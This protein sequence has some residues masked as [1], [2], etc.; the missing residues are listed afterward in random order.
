MARS[1]IPKLVR[2]R[3]KERFDGRCGYCGEKPRA[4]VID[5]VI[6]VQSGGTNIESNL[7]PA[8]ASCNNYKMVWS[9]ERFREELAEQVNRLRQYSVNYRLAERFGLVAPTGAQIVFHFEKERSD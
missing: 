7:M 3:V 9:L 2:Q 1:P 8:C 4:L 6:P 5:H